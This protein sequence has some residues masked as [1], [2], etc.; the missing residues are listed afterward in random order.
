M[1]DTILWLPFL[2]A[3]TLL[4]LW[5]SQLAV[6]NDDEFGDADFLAELDV[7]KIVE[8]RRLSSCENTENKR[9][10]TSPSMDDFRSTLRSI[11][12][13]EDFRPGQ[14][15]VIQSV[16]V[17]RRDAAVFW[18]TGRGKSLNYQIPALHTKSTAIV[19][20]PLISLMQDQVHKLNGL[21][22]EPLATFLGSGQQDGSAERLALQGAFRL[23]YI[24]PEKLLSGNFLS[25]LEQ[26]HRSSPIVLFAVD[27]AH[28]VSEW[29]HDFRPEFRQVGEALRGARASA[30]LRDVPILALTATAVPKVQ[31]DIMQSLRL[32]NPYQARQSFDR[33]N[34]RIR[35]AKKAPGGV[36]TSLKS[37]LDTLQ[38]PTVRV[39]Q[40]STIVYAPTRNQ[41]EE[42]VAFLQ[43]NL[44]PNSPVAVAAYHAGLSNEVRSRAHTD[45]LTGRTTVIVATVAFG[46]GIDKPDTRRIVHFGPPKT[47]EEY[48]QQIGRAGRDGVVADC[49][50]Y[51]AENDF[52]RYNSEFY[53]G[54]LSGQALQATKDSMQALRNYALNMEKCRRKALLDYFEEA[55]SFGERCGTCDNCLKVATYGDDSQRDFGPLGA[56]VVLQAVSELAEQGATTI[57]NIIGGRAVENYRYIGRNPAAVQMRLQKMKER[58]HKAYPKEFYKELLSALVQ[59]KLIREATKQTTMDG[60][61]RSWTVYSVTPEG[62]RL[63]RTATAPIVLPVP[64]LVRQIERKEEER[65][66]RVL[67]KLEENGV[68]RQNLPAK[69]LQDG[70]G[71]VVRAYSKWHNYLEGIQQKGQEERRAQLDELVASIETWRSEVAVA[72]RMAPAS[73]LAEHMLVSVAYTLATLPPGQKLDAESLM[74]AGVRSKEVGSLVAVLA[75]WVDQYRPAVA[76][77]DGSGPSLIDVSACHFDGAKKWKHAV[78]KPQKKSG[79]AVWELSY[80]R[81]DKG[82]SPQAIAMLPSD[83]RKPIQAKTVVGHIFDAA[84]NGRKVDFTRLVDLMPPPNTLEWKQLE[85]AEAAQA[86]DCTGDPETSG[87]DG[88]RFGMTDMLQPIVGDEVANKGFSERT[89][90]EKELFSAWCDKLK[91]YMTLRRIDYKF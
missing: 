48:Y 14:A 20:S 40:Q 77:T 52:D 75:A 27:E 42:I 12:G 46:M 61:T 71:P 89:E 53:L 50:M 18:A 60:F 22:A 36:S 74:A 39:A 79:K 55:A 7:D 17:E 44:G 34:L 21:S 33:S 28:C 67:A 88:M 83:G 76:V 81:F 35:V 84:I 91:W 5:S 16:A 15:E 37:L 26:L 69:E 32:R 43:Q 65:R 3:P 87:K 31:A 64:E 56:R 29:G 4:G 2:F 23:V 6:M 86:M 90:A 57:L 41:V 73:V 59:K 25:S 78:Y 62:V 38:E 82:E 47:M 9:Q 51:V 24:T 80:D 70:D 19:I 49:V 66:Q 58:V 13:F 1:I 45:F 30:S 72:H 8:E 54:K 68:P 10:K 11:F 63:L 85:D